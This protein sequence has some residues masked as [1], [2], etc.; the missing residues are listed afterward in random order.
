MQKYLEKR[1][2]QSVTSENLYKLAE[3][4]LKHSYFEFG[5]DVYRQIL[6]TAIGTKF[7]TPYANI[8]MTGLVEE[9]FKNPK[10][11]PFPCLRYLDD[12]FCLWTEG[13][14]KLK[15]FFNYLNEFHPSTSLPWSI[16]KN[17]LI[18]SMFLSPNLMQV[19]NCAQ[20]STL[21]PQ[22]CTVLTRHVMSSSSVQKLDRLWA[23]S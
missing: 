8:F 5:Q 11:K 9:I 10:F 19:K 20:V 2:D 21:K 6:G 12:I 4:V 3:F 13:V 14:D 23:S 15:E 17:K 16:L 18:S 7:A 22:T 1:E